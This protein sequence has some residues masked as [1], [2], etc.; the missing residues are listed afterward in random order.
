MSDK[1]DPVSAITEDE[2]TGETAI[3]FEEIR[4]TMQIPMLTSIW[5][6]LASSL[7]QLKTAWQLTKPLFETGF[8]ETV[9]HNLY[10]STNFPVPPPLADGQQQ[11]L[12]VLEEDLLIIK[13]IVDTREVGGCR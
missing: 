7:G 9:L 2:A 11:A 1:H 8:P 3:L 6:I 4:A 13:A 10:R 5:R 12:G